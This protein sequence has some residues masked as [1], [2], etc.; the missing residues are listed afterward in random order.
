MEIKTLSAYPGVLFND[1]F[2]RFFDA[3]KLEEDVECYQLVFCPYGRHTSFDDLYKI[4]FQSRVVILNVVD[5]I[6]DG[7]D[8]IGY[9]ELTKFC[10][11]HPEQNFIIFNFNLGFKDKLKIPN[12]YFDTIFSAIPT[13]RL[14]HCQKKNLTNRWI[15]LNADTKLHRVMTVCYLLSKEYHENGY[16]TFDMETPPLARHDQYRNFT[17]IPSYE[18][19]SS[20]A[21]GYVKFKSKS[22]NRLNVC[23]FDK[24]DDRVAD[25][26]NTNLLPV[27]ERI[28]LE[29]ITGTMFF[30]SIPSLSEKE[31]QS[32]YAK[33]FPIY[34]NGVGTVRE[35]R[36]LFGIDMFDDVI[37][38]SYD[39]IENH[40]ERLAAAIDRNE[41]LL[42]GSTNIRELWYDNQKRFEDNCERMDSLIFD[43]DHRQIVNNEKIKN[44]LTHFGV[45]FV[46]N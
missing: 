5:F 8:N 33:N 3:Y 4:N 31:V 27:Y 26:Y 25:N 41:H 6:I 22:F 29:I 28:G 18:L 36:K 30:E 16:I 11:D 43:A 7:V 15:S 37:D 17:K 2:E 12:L 34:I 24:E 46:K 45:S 20:I 40:F 9:D 32:V 23:N 39:E 38:H 13:E 14:A 44:A 21:V 19:R 10:S 35:I 42:N 1:T